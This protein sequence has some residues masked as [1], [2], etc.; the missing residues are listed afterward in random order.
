MDR[1]LGTKMQQETAHAH[2]F[3]RDSFFVATKLLSLS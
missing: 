1:M 3:G 2:S